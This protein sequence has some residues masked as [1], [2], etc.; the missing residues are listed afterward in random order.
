[1]IY[2]LILKAINSSVINLA[3]TCI[4]GIYYY[5]TL[6]IDCKSEKNE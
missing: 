4:A 3:I 5:N 2:T 6:V 1:M